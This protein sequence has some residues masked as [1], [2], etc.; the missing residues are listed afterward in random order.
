MSLPDFLNTLFA[1][2][3]AR[4]GQPGQVSPEHLG[5]ASALLMEFEQRAQAEFPGEPP[6]YLPTVGLWGAELF[7]RACQLAVCRD[8]GAEN[9]A[10]AL[11]P[12]CP[13]PLSPAV[14]YSVDLVWQF[15]PDLHRLTR[16]AAPNDPLV[17]EILRLAGE[18]PLSSV[19]IA[20][21]QPRSIAELIAH[22]GLLT[23]YVD[24]I[25]AR[26]D[27]S[28]LSDPRVRDAVAAAIG[29]HAALAPNFTAALKTPLLLQSTQGVAP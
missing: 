6:P 10:A 16:Q 20:D 19:G 21:V 1:H 3:R 17:G 7:Y 29:A 28:R 2:G 22:R 4:V 12:R 18:W 13:Q 8:L 15:L 24:R 27:T 25:L 23:L 14:H 9:I 26:G 5:Q 11:A